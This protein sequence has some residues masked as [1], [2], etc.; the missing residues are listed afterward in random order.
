M[1]GKVKLFLLG[2]WVILESLAD[3]IQC[4][5]DCLAM[6]YLG[7]PLG[8]PFKKSSIWNPIL[9][10]MERKLSGWKCLYLSKGGRLTLL[11]STLSSLPTYHLSLFTIPKSM[12]DRL[13]RIQRNFLRG[14][15]DEGFTYPL[16]AWDKIC[17]HIEVGGLGIR[18]I[19]CFNQAL[20]GKWLWRFGRSWN[21]RFHRNLHNWETETA[22]SFLDRIYSQVPRGEGNDRMPLYLK[23]SGKFDTRTYYP[24]IRGVNN[25][26]FPWKGVFG[27]LRFLEGLYYFC[28]Q[29]LRV[30]FLRWITLW[31]CVYF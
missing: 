27:L 22:V 5:V 26:S 16:V 25:F 7:M 21:L 4:R 2:M 1:W 12:A 13:E 10:K 17:S 14:A 3:V 24:V 30:G 20:L 11:K 31:G 29:Q 15:S 9:E 18:R 23:G 28:G 8:S 19:V 6:K